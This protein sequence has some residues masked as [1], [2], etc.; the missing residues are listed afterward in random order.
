M[1]YISFFFSLSAV[2][3]NENHFLIIHSGWANRSDKRVVDST[4]SGRL[5]IQRGN[6]IEQK[7]IKNKQSTLK[8][9]SAADVENNRESWIVDRNQQVCGSKKPKNKWTHCKSFK[10]HNQVAVGTHRAHHRRRA[11]NNNKVIKWQ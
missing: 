5:K 8:E 3:V 11:M 10:R 7:K 6:K 9:V 4:A 1:I 2:A